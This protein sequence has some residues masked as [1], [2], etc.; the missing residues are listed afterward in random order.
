MV[1]LVIALSTELVVVM[2][3]DDAYAMTFCCSKLMKLCAV[4]AEWSGRGV[5]RW[6]FVSGGTHASTA[7]VYYTQLNSAAATKSMIAEL[8]FCYCVSGS[9]SN[10][11]KKKHKHAKHERTKHE[12]I[13][14]KQWWLCVHTECD[15]YFLCFFCINYLHID[16]ITDCCCFTQLN[17]FWL[18]YNIIVWRWNVNFPK[19]RK[20][21]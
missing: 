18:Y 19:S 12:R 2:W 17:N 5:A 1:I 6:T 13:V 3:C 4:G 20:H 21:A 9:K 11:K 8:T 15:S 16:W 14:D 7:N 10:K